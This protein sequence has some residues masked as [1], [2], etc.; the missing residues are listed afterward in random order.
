MDLAG[1]HLGSLV[2]GTFTTLDAVPPQISSTLPVQ[3]AKNVP[4]ETQIRVVFSEAVTLESLSGPALQLFDVDDQVGVATTFTLQPQAR[5][6]LI[7]PIAVLAPD[8]VHR[9]TIQ[10]VRDP[11]GNIML[12]P[13][14]LNF[15]SA[16][17]TP[18]VVGSISPAAGSSVTSGHTIDICYLIGH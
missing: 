2:Q 17:I 1:R 3:N 18:P 4:V 5:E 14:V 13:F 12:Q 6:V 15:E 16:D 8:H 7:T 9:L 10:G 11:V